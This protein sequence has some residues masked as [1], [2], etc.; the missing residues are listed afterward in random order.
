MREENSLGGTL[1][2]KRVPERMVK[3]LRQEY[4]LAK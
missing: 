2:R 3:G 1:L 4:G